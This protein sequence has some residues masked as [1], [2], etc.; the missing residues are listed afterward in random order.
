[1][2]VK[3]ITL[4]VKHF[5]KSKY[6]SNKN[7]KKLTDALSSMF[8]VIE[9]FEKTGKVDGK[10]DQDKIDVLKN[11]ISDMIKSED[12]KKVIDQWPKL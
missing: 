4:D 5:D 1:M 3:D 12:Q 9:R 7:K 8:D 11:V 2:K 6:L 10:S